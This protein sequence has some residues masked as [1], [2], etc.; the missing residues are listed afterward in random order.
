MEDPPIL[1]PGEGSDSSS[2]NHQNVNGDQ[3]LVV[4]QA[5]NSNVIYVAGDGNNVNFHGQGSHP[6]PL[7]PPVNIDHSIPREEYPLRQKLL[8]RV[9]DYWVEGLLVHSFHKSVLAELSM[10]VDRDL[11]NLTLKDCPE[12]F[13]IDGRTLLILGE[14]GSGKTTIL[15]KIAKDLISRTER[16]LRQQMP[17][18]FNLSSWARESQT[19]EEWIVR[20][21]SEK[22]QVSTSLG[23]EWVNRESLILLLDGLDEVKSEYRNA[24]VQALNEFLGTHGNTELIVCCRTGDH[25]TLTNSLMLRRV[26]C[27][28]PLTF[29]QINYYLKWTGKQLN[30]LRQC[31]REDWV[32]RHL[33]T[34]PFMLNIMCLAYQGCKPGDIDRFGTAEDYSKHL[35][36]AYIYRMLHGQKIV[37]KYPKA[38]QRLIDLARRMTA[39]SQTIMLSQSPK[40]GFTDLDLLDLIKPV[41]STDICII[42][43]IVIIA[44]V[45]L[46]LEYLMSLILLIISAL[47]FVLLIL[48][49]A[50]LCWTALRFKNTTWKYPYP[51]F[52]NYAT[53]K[54]FLRKVGSGY[55]FANRMLRDHFAAIPIDQKR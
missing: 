55:I 22:Y 2:E 39:E 52:L 6:P 41:N 28:Q 25:Q 7:L 42:A 29:E 33:S 24:C 46:G 19:I 18:V 50:R 36:N 54:L 11:I 48:G 31:W 17:V 8:N 10:P 35:F 34:A 15:M 45:V 37:Q 27:V 23:R 20:E 4:A 53:K 14:P 40:I 21:L 16:D 51:G 32:L 5:N 30:A 1:P 12:F 49:T 47:V 3:N 13:E 26:V 38:Q 44:I 43:T 9:H